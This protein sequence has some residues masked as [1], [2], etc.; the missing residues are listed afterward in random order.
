MVL[1]NENMT[2]DDSGVKNPKTHPQGVF[3]GWKNYVDFERGWEIVD[4]PLSKIFL[5]L[6]IWQFYHFVDHGGFTLVGAAKIIEK[7]QHL[8]LVLFNYSG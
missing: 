3:L 8:L 6:E 2:L 5:I 1:S 7:N 4:F